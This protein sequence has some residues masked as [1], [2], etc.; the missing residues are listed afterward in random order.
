MSSQFSRR[1]L[2]R[3]GLAV[4]A[5]LA[6]V[7]FAVPGS[8]APTVVPQG[9][10]AELRALESRHAARLGVHAINIRSGAVVSYRAHERFPMCSTFKT[11]AVAAV[12]RDLDH[13][14]E[15]LDSWVHYTEDD[16][17][18]NS[19]VTE[20]HV[21][22]G[23]RVEQ[24]CAAAIR[25]SDNTAA[26]L[27]LRRL[28]GP[29]GVT[30]FCRSLGDPVTRLDRYEP[31]LSDAVPGDPR[32]TTTPAAI[33]AD[34]R[35]LVLGRALC[36]ADRERLTTWLTES[37]TSDTRFRAGLPSHWRLADKTGSGG[38]GTANDVG[39]AW[40]GDGA[41]LV[42]AVLSTK[43][44]EGAEWDDELVARTASVLARAL[45]E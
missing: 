19:P 9:V 14:G 2:L 18:P 41:P 16:L 24:L 29:G 11:L 45:V 17:V 33:A 7:G 38:Y 23:M 44:V 26:N 36:P 27:L 28:G 8:G 42:L 32:D 40:T 4:T 15:F 12:L 35:R 34:Y 3:T 39:V 25:K 10:R 6:T 13:D 37:V 21:G 31:E 20:N 30:R 22:R 43:H 1:S 5:G